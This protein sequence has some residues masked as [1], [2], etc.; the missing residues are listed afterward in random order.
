EPP[1]NNR[2]AIFAALLAVKAAD[3]NH[4]LM[5]FTKS[6]YVIRHSCYWAGK[7]SQIGWSCANGDLLKDLTFLLARRR[8]PTRFV[9]IE[10]G[11]KNPRAEAAMRLAKVG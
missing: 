9:R 8:A 11:V 6:E 7:N 4:S 1:T 10:H 5:I 3:P 2:A